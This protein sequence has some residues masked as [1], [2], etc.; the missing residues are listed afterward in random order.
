MIKVYKMNGK[1]EAH[2]IFTSPSG[3]T[4]FK[5]TFTKGNLDPK[6]RVPAKYATASPVVQYA[7]EHSPKFNKTVFLD[8]VY[9]ASPAAPAS[10]PIASAAPAKEAKK[11]GKGKGKEAT[12][13][14]LR[15]MPDVLTLAD[16]ATVLTSEGALAADF[17]GTVESAQKLAKSFG[18]SFPNLKGEE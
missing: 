8:K 2:E 10:E 9:G 11:S 3:K 15:E 14:T 16:A 1:T 12:K 6:N 18:L 4:T 5:V 7:I 17:D 13:E